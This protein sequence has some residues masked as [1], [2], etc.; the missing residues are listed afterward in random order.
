MRVGSRDTRGW[1]SPRIAQQRLGMMFAGDVAAGREPAACAELPGWWQCPVGLLVSWWLWVSP[2]HAAWLCPV[3]GSAAVLSPWCVRPE[4]LRPGH[5][6]RA[7]QSCGVLS[8]Q[9][10][11][12]LRLRSPSAH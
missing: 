5:V 6:G 1:L 3:P 10:G 8:C 11:D 2:G 12:A 7:S 4:S 9:A